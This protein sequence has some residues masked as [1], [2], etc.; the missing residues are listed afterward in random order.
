MKHYIKISII[1]FGCIVAM[2]CYTQMYGLLFVQTEPVPDRIESDPI[3]YVVDTVL[4][5]PGGI[6]FTYPVG[7]FTIAPC[8]IVHAEVPSAIADTT[9]TITLSNNSATSVMVTVY[10]ITSSGGVPTGMAEATLSDNVT[11]HLWAL[12]I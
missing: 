5:A 3:T 8:V 1:L 10:V 9:Y 12:G 4:Y 7:A 11:V 6:T 2:P